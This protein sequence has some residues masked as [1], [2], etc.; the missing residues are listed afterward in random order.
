MFVSSRMR[1]LILF[2]PKK[3]FLG[4]RNSPIADASSSFLQIFYFQ[5]KIQILLIMRIAAIKRTEFFFCSSKQDDKNNFQW[6]SGSFISLTFSYELFIQNLPFPHHHYY[7]RI[8]LKLSK[9]KM[10]NHIPKD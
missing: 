3:K 5:S 7:G 4:F 6:F 10:I 8:D 9:K 2:F 1:D